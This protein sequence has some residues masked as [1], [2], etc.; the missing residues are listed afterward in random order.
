MHVLAAPLVCDV[1]PEPVDEVDVV[2][3]QARRVRPE[4]KV[5]DPPVRLDDAEQDLALRP[6]RQLLPRLAEQA[7]LLLRRHHGRAARDDLRR[8]ELR[9]GVRDGLED[10]R[11][12]HDQEVNV[13]AGL[14]RER[15]DA[16][17]E[18]LLVAGEEVLLAYVLVAGVRPPHH[19][20]G[21]HDQVVLAR[22]RQLKRL[23]DVFERVVV[24]H[25]AQRIAGSHF[26]CLVRHNVLRLQSELIHLYVGSRAALSLVDALRDEK[27]DEEDEGEGDAADGRHLLRDEVDARDR[28]EQRRDDAESER[29]L[30]AV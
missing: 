4:V 22:V 24:A 12:G 20:H 21:H 23:P 2:F 29:N 25:Q 15:H 13:L 27:D 6:V 11:R 10:V 30:V 5:A 16:A 9:G 14:L 3:V 18:Q 8:F 1:E 28:E 26:D 17:E 19:L 7:R